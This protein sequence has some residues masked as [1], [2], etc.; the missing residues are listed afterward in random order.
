MSIY[1]NI[2]SIIE[3]K[4][5]P[6]AGKIG[7]QRHVLAVRDGFISAMP[8]MIVGSF[9]MILA[10]P[11][12][13]KETTFAFGQMWL[14]F[15]TTHKDA[16]MLPFRMTMGIMT[17]YVAVG[18][19]YNLSQ[20]YN[21]SPLMGGLLSLCSFLIVAAPFNNG[22]IP[23]MFMGGT[24]I[25]TALLTSIFSVEL[26]R[27]LKAKNFTI[28]LPEQVPEKIAQSFELL[29]PVLVMIATLYPLSLILQHAS[30]LLLPELIMEIFKPLV[31]ASD[32]LTAVLICVLV[33]H[34]LWFCG[35]HGAAIVTNLLQ[36]FWLANI[37]ANQM[38]LE[39][40]QVLPHSFV[41]PFWRFYIVIGGC[42]ST[43]ALVIMYMRSRSAHLRSIGK[44]SVVPSFFNINEPV[45]FGSPIIMNPIML[46]PFVGAP[47][48]N[49]S[50][51]W[52]ALSSGF[53]DKPISIVPWTTP[54]LLGAPW[55]AGWTFGP[56]LLVLTN[57]AISCVIWLPFFK[58][59]E[60]Q[61][62]AQENTSTS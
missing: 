52:F 24:G 59:Y 10:F 8:F 26:M 44:L 32:S 61:L 56:I 2:I 7:G 17:I 19:G 34:L 6:V 39:M 41:D 25:F 9:L 11:P 5:A 35:I 38:A 15:A 3:R 33:S 47:L 13:S 28:R 48:V 29:V 1:N 36:P 30:G 22:N 50:V 60:K 4:I 12:F 31:S 55:A 37:A 43:L 20:G 62:I 57:F 21:L 14:E 23:A 27:F 53:V 16:I 45:I 40:G 58:A 49:A 46:I 42:G 18:I 51:A 54:S